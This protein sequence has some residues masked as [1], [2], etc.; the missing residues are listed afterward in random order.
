MADIKRYV[1]VAPYVTLR[2][3]TQS[4]PRILGF[5][6]GAPVPPDVPDD[7]IQHHLSKKMIVEVADPSAVGAEATPTPI[8]RM[9]WAEAGLDPQAEVAKRV[10]EAEH[11]RNRVRGAVKAAETRKVNAETDDAP[12]TKPEGGAEP[13]AETKA[14]GTPVQ[15]VQVNKK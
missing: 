7:Q 6:S 4:G 8:E 9:E 3:M 15:P 12:E 5:H 11:G 2:T 10:E 13:K 1:V 14:G